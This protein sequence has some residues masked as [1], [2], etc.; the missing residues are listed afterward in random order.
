MAKMSPRNSK[1]KTKPLDLNTFYLHQHSFHWIQTQ[2]RFWLRESFNYLP[3]LLSSVTA[4]KLFIE[5]WSLHHKLTL[6]TATRI[7]PRNIFCK[8][9]CFWLHS[10]KKWDENLRAFHMKMRATLELI[11]KF[12]SF[13]KSRLLPRGRSWKLTWNTWFRYKIHVKQQRSEEF[14]LVLFIKFRGKSCCWRK[15]S[16]DE[17]YDFHVHR[18]SIDIKKKLVYIQFIW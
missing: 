10:G 9:F 12:L 8:T 2:K 14:K 13:W 17:F 5:W 18:P 6:C 4:Q 11:R 7:L 3:S 1:R 16:G 15:I